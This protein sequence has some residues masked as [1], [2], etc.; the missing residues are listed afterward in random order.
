[1][2]CPAPEPNPN[3]FVAGCCG[4]ALAGPAKENGV[5]G[6][7]ANGWVPNAGLAGADPKAPPLADC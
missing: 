7:G 6:A 4:G 2:G 5:D 3:G 1:V